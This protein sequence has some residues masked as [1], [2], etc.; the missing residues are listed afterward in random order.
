MNMER[1]LAIKVMDIFEEFL[2]SEGIVIPS[3][4][5]VGEE[6]EACIFGDKYYTLED[7]ITDLLECDE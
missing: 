4:D 7:K 6:S 1:E 2:S 5:R 3:D